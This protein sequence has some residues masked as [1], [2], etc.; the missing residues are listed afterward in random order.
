[1]EADKLKSK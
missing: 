1:M